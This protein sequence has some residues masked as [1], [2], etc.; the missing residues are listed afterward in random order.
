MS[1]STKSESETGQFY[2][3]TFTSD[4]MD[5]AAERSLAA[6]KNKHKMTLVQLNLKTTKWCLDFKVW[7]LETFK[8]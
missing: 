2:G 5:V 6:H 4:R 3:N 1:K 8:S 7:V